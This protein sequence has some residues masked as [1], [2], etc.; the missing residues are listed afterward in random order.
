MVY[1]LIIGKIISILLLPV[2]APL[3]MAWSGQNDENNMKW[4]KNPYL[5][6]LLLAAAAVIAI[7]IYDRQR[8]SPVDSE[9]LEFFSSS[10][11][12]KGINDYLSKQTITHTAPEL[13]EIIRKFEFA[14]YA[15]KKK[16]FEEAR[17]ALDS[18][19]KGKDDQGPLLKI[20]S[21]LVLNNLG[22]VWF[23]IQRNKQFKA[24]KM[25]LSAMSLVSQGGSHIDVIESNI[26]KLDTMTNRVD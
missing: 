19:S 22:C 4:Y 25:L 17:R 2:L 23:K 14:E 11:Y 6:G 21:A 12:E 26:N 24:S 20:P 18:L 7:E 10:D 8:S 3:A 1:V 9:E 5:Y 15:W 16:D 13:R